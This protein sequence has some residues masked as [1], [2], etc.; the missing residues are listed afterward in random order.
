MN[1]IKF[2]K[3]KT[4]IGLYYNIVELDGFLDNLACLLA[5]EIGGERDSSWIDFLKKSKY[6]EMS[7]NEIMLEKRGVVVYISNLHND[8][9]DEKYDKLKISISELLEVI[10][11]WEDLLDK[12]P[13]EINLTY[14][15]GKF[16]LMENK[17]KTVEN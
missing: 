10:K 6:Q 9:F 11:T 12:G 7:G 3:Y 15:D 13:E 17:I 16:D 1:I 8:N 2:L 4:K 5:H 14:K